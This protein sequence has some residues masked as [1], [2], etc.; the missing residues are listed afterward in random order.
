V[1]CVEGPGAK[2]GPGRDNRVLDR[3]PVVGGDPDIL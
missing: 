1:A 3:V 2:L